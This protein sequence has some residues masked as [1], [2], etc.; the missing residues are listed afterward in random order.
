MT[1]DRVEAAAKALWAAGEAAF[2]NKG[3][4]LLWDS[5]SVAEETREEWRREMALALAA[6]DEAD[7]VAGVVRLADDAASIERYCEMLHDAYEKA[8]EHWGW[9]T[10][11]ASRKPWADVPERN[12]MTMRMALGNM[13]AAVAAAS[14]PKEGQRND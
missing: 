13:L 7:R 6:A 11:P 9:A 8:A 1:G 14:V 4:R 10:N 3:K 12:K 2:I 5:K